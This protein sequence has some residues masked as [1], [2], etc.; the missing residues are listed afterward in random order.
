MGIALLLLGSI[1]GVSAMVFVNASLGISPKARLADIDE[2]AARLDADRVGFEAA[3][4][5]LAKDGQ[6]AL[7]VSRAGDCLGLLVAR[8]SDFVIRYLTP[9]MIREVSAEGE[10]GLRVRLNDFVF[11]PAHL[12][13]ETA[14]TASAWKDRLSA[15]AGPERT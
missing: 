10:T 15:L 9:G 3:D 13:F 14:E 6:G 11:A 1:L 5:V 7:V 8:G 12:E 2:A 4:A